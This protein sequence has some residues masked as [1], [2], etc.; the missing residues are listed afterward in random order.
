M[1]CPC[2]AGD[3]EFFLG[4]PVREALPGTGLPEGLRTI[5]VASELAGRLLD[6]AIRG[7]VSSRYWNPEVCE[8]GRRCVPGWST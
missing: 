8:W 2:F 5:G 7:E 1:E 3:M 6:P 4:I